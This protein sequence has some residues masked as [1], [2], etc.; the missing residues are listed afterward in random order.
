[1]VAALFIC[2]VFIIIVWLVFFQY[3]WLK[4]S[5]TWGVVS[6]LILLHLLLI[7]LVGM[8]FM[9][10]SSDTA[11]MVQYTIQLTPRL[12]QP[13]M[14]TEVL[15]AQNTPVKKGQPLFKF[16]RRPYEFQ[17]NQLQAKLAQAKQEVKILKAD[18]VIAKQKIV[19]AESELVYA[20][21][22][23]KLTSGLATQGAGPSEEAQKAEAQVKVAQATVIQA[24]AETE[25][26]ELKYNSKINGVNTDVAALQ[27]EL[28]EAQFFLDNTTMY[29]PE[30]GY[31]FNLQV[32]PGMIAGEVRFGAIAS[33][34][35]DNDRYLLA[36]YFQE[37][38]K[39][40]K[41]KQKVEVALDL[42]P[43]QIFTG[44]VE[45]IWQ[46]SGAG[47]YLPSGTMPQ[48]EPNSPQ[49]PQGQFAVK[50]IM[51]DPDQAK[52]PIGAQGIAAIYTEPEDFAFL[53]K[54]TLRASSWFNW[55]YPFNE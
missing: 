13:T 2:S 6:A 9:T 51:D 32:R 10:Q 46:G 11:R 31:V 53:R 29:A 5:I 52:F 45:S 24:K 1:M 27:A 3:K 37:N 8:R 22:Q 16:D 41:P 34:V 12:S 48:Y 55:L 7:F 15:V 17:V 38:L 18:V 21:Y 35:C 47:Q 39:Y 26:E 43:G 19:Q 14:V 25:R 49:Q 36:S 54:I 23:A 33:F 42:Y 44:Y 50:I 4:F 20:I 28:Q 40:V 30:D